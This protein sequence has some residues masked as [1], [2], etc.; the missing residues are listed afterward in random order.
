MSQEINADAL[1]EAI[2]RHREAKKLT[3]RAAAAEMDNVSPSTLSRIERGSLPDLDTYMR[4]CRWL[5]VD[6]AYF[7]STPPGKKSPSAESPLKKEDI[8]T[9]LRADKLL[10]QQTREALITMIEVAYAAA[11]RNIFPDESQVP[12]PLQG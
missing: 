1:A 7:A 9:H 3:G 11:R 4:I 6:P 8:I 2:V 12:P 5:E 10:T